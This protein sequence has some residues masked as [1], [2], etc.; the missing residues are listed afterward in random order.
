[1]RYRVNEVWFGSASS[2]KEWAN[3]RTEMYAD[4][5]DWLGGGAIDNDPGLFRDLTAPEYDYHGKAQDAVMLESKEAMKDR[6]LPSP[7]DGDALV[8]TFASKVA[9]KDIRASRHSARARQ[10]RDVNYSVFG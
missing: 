10:A 1:M 9:R 2:S 4:C 3:K 7:D 5:R 8:L 6:G